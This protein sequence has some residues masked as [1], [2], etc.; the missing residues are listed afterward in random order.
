MHLFASKDKGFMEKRS[1]EE[2]ARRGRKGNLRRVDDSMK[3]RFVV[4]LLV[5]TLALC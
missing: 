3:V 4:N 5:V 2:N 1:I